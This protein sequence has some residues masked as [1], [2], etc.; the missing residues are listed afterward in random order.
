MSVLDIEGESTALH[1]HILHQNEEWQEYCQ[2]G[3][4]VE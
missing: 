4:W 2:L 1:Q 3:H